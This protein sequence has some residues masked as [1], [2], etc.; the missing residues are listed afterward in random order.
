MRATS[1]V[2]ACACAARC[3]GL[4]ERLTIEYEKRRLNNLGITKPLEWKGLDDNY[5]GYDILS[6][7][8]KAGTEINIM[9]EVKSTITSPL[10]FYLSRNEWETADQIGSAY[11][12]HVWNMA[13][14]PPQ[15]YERTVEQIRPHIPSDNGQG[16]WSHVMIPIVIKAF[17]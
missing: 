16:K 6:V 1:R 14:K 9:I 17:T 10:R 2:S 12:F 4:A 7:D 5:A 15:L 3:T 13:V 8:L 11:I